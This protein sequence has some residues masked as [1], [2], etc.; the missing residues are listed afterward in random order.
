MSQDIDFERFVKDPNLL[1]ELCREVIDRVFVK[2]D[3]QKTGQE[4]AQLREIA[5]AIDKL[6][7]LG[8]PVPEALRA[9]KTRLAGDLAEQARPRQL[10]DQLS[11]ELESFVGELK[12]RLG[13]DA[14]KPNRKVTRRKR[15]RSPK[16]NREILRQSIIKALTKVGGRAR[17]REV[18][19][20]VEE[21]LSGKLL[22]GD[23][24]ICQDGRSLYWK[25]NTQWER[26][27]MINDGILRSDSPRGF[28][29]LTENL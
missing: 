21:Q 11:D 20:D 22:P 6:E 3:D 1:I 14:M 4:E 9:E 7:K 17:A 16:T 5:R 12:K 25:K 15:S 2:S 8:V 26:L 28:W 29:E 23:F 19:Q 18:L 24:E 10:L 13:R 27:R